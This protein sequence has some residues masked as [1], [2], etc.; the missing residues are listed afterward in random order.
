[1]RKQR[2]L[3]RPLQSPLY[4]LSIS[5]DVMHERQCIYQLIQRVQR[6]QRVSKHF[7]YLIS[8]DLHYPT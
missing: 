8:F 7:F 1:M 3:K 4:L 5:H 6:I 2:R